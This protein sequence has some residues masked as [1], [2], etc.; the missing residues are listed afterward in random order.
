MRRSDSKAV[1]LGLQPYWWKYMSSERGK[2]KDR[3]SDQRPITHSQSPHGLAEGKEDALVLLGPRFPLLA[4]RP[5]CSLR[6]SL[7]TYGQQAI[8]H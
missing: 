1:V 7:I 3:A 8:R 5:P 4:R 2:H 6:A